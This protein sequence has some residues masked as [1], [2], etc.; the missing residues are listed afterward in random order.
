VSGVASVS[1]TISASAINTSQ[2]SLAASVEAS[3]KPVLEVKNLRKVFKTH[4]KVRNNSQNR[5]ES[6]AVDNV[7]FSISEGECLGLVG[8]SGSGKSTVAKMVLRLLEV[9]SGEI[10]L[11]GENITQ[12]KGKQ[13]AGIYANM[14]AVFQNPVDSFDP[15]RTLGASIAEGMRNAG[16]SKQEST[17]RVYELLDMCGLPSAIAQRFPREVSGGQ[18]QRAA[19]ARALALQ[20][21]L[22]VCDEVTSALDVTV[23]RQIMDLLTNLRAELNMAMLFICHDIALV[24][25]VCDQVIVMHNGKIEEQGSARE[26]IQNPQSAYAQTLIASVL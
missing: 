19:I 5:D 9:T 17:A 6:V 22:L 2:V 14:Q 16:V 20:P 8:E 3:G 15:R 24:Q 23:Q 12:V 13:L 25:G 7:S 1:H 4:N 21:K 26:I 11:L 10:F 18:C